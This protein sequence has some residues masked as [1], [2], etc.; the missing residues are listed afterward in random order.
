METT[1]VGM[2]P[3]R[4]LKGMRKYHKKHRAHVLH[5]QRFRDVNTIIRSKQFDVKVKLRPL[6]TQQR[7]FAKCRE[8]IRRMEKG[9]IR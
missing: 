7:Y 1:N 3:L 6:A 8:S 9:A 5:C 2:M 4:V